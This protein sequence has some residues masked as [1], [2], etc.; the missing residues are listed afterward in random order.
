LQLDILN[1]YSFKPKESE[2][3]HLPESVSYTHVHS[4]YGTSRNDVCYKRNFYYEIK[5]LVWA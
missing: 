3:S 4:Q 5:S 2:I 1:N